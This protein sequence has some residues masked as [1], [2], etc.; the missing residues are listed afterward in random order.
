VDSGRTLAT[1]YTCLL[2]CSVNDLKLKQETRDITEAGVNRRAG[3]FTVFADTTPTLSELR[4]MMIE[5]G[6]KTEVT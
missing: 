5:V 4:A 3:V 6:A 2:N 1:S